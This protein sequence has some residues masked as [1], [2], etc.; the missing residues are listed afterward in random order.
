MI[1]TA[2]LTATDP[3]AAL[4]EHMRGLGRHLHHCRKSQGPFFGL[5]RIALAMHGWVAPRFVTTLALAGVA[6]ALICG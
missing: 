1:H 5:N 6:I 2:T 4:R 3:H